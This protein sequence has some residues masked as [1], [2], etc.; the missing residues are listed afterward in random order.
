MRASFVSFSAKDHQS[1][2][3]TKGKESK[4]PILRFFLKKKLKNT[5]TPLKQFFIVNVY[6]NCVNIFLN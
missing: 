6:P 4:D 1:V 3:K 2:F 5:Y